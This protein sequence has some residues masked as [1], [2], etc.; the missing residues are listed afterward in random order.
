MRWCFFDNLYQ[1]VS[2]RSDLQAHPYPG[3]GESCSFTLVPSVVFLTS[4][5]LAQASCFPH[6][7]ACRVTGRAASAEGEDFFSRC[8][9]PVAAVT[10][11][12]YLIFLLRPMPHSQQFPEVV[13]ACQPLCPCWRVGQCRCLGSPGT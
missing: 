3:E 6:C 8:I 12:Y 11:S 7:R 2:W 5:S 10:F 1:S 9:S 4:P 13:A